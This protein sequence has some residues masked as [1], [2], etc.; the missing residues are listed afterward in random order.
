MKPLRLACLCLA[1][2]SLSAQNHLELPAT[3][4]PS[5]ELN[6][7]DELP[8][9]QPNARVQMLFD[10]TE[11]GSTTF[12]ADQ[13]ELRWDGPI[14]AVGA[15][16]PFAITR[17]RVRIGTTAVAAPG[18]DFAANLTAPLLTVLDAP[19]S[20]LPD[21]GFGSPH[22]W[23]GPGGTLR[24]PF[25]QPA[26]VVIGPGEWLVVEL[27]MEGNNIQN[28]GFAHAILDGATTTG[29]PGNGTAQAYGQGCS[30]SAAAPP[31]S[32]G[33]TGVFAPGGAHFLGGTNLGAGAV[34]VGAFGLSDT[35]AFVPLPFTLPGTSCTLLAS[36]D[37]TPVAFADAAGALGGASRFALVVPPDPAL[38]GI[39]VYEQLA[40][41][42]PGANAWGIVL[43]NAVAV[44]LGPWAPAGRGTWTVAHDSDASA[45][46]ANVVEAFGFAVRLRTL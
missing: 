5:F 39:V 41:L 13:L 22:P 18:A 30:A 12:V 26:P 42:A 46:F 4:A 3:A 45:P 43:S 17:L 37:Y 16:G 8:F 11:V 38:G 35:T 29:G 33:A 34:V 19:W 2:A 6:G 44:T 23:G 28:F 31:A 20:Y 9:M 24:F 40:S 25:T 32:A 36:P 21:N 7:F 27:V 1:A 10:A 15:P 14:P